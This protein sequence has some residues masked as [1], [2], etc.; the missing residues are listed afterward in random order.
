MLDAA[1]RDP[2]T[3]LWTLAEGSR[4]AAGEAGRTK[5]QGLL[6]LDII[7]LQDVNDSL[8]HDAGDALL[9]TAA[10]RLQEQVGQATVCARIGGDELMVLLQGEDPGPEEVARTVGGTVDLAGARFELRIRAGYCAA[11]DGD[12][13]QS[14]LRHAQAA[15]SR[16]AAGGA[17]YRSWT[18]ELTV[19]PTRRLRLAGD[20][21]T[22]LAQGHVFPVFQPLCRASD[23]VVVGAE[24]L[25]RWHHP[26]LGLVR[27]D[28]FIA[29]AEQT[30]LIGELTT[31]VLDKALAQA[32]SWRDQGLALRV[33][34]NLSPRSLT[35]GGLIET[36][37]EALDKHGLPPSALLLEITESTIMSNVEQASAVLARL[38]A[39]GVHTAL[40]D[41]GTGHSSL[42]QLRAI[43]VDEV[44][45]DRSFLAGVE[46]DP[47]ARRVIATA[48]AL[49]H[50][51]GK[52]VVAEGVEDEETAGFLHDSGVD[53]LQGY[54]LGRPMPADD[55]SEHLL[56]R[57]PGRVPLVPAQGTGVAVARTR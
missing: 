39:G 9:R 47:A 16:S 22:A 19:D 17:R 50:D 40:D 12:S 13:F 25:A 6:V 33:S 27:P 7:G 43:P 53:L 29:I 51:L 48:V 46:A 44:K 3:G 24:A 54:Y 31:V 38:R 10:R 32:R 56:A 23:R 14:L 21:Q 5:A 49:C 11:A 41:F 8:R 57:A 42:T 2:L 1:G 26:H 30:G 55:W 34:V 18:P 36:V 52:T 35:E 45:L 37:E 15:L 4:R 20:L 28:E